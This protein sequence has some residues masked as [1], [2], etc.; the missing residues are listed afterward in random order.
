MGCRCCR[1]DGRSDR[2]SHSR[3]IGTQ[4]RAVTKITDNRTALIVRQVDELWT[5]VE[6]I[7]A[8][9]RCSWFG[10][11]PELDVDRKVHKHFPLSLFKRRDFKVELM[12]DGKQADIYVYCRGEEYDKEYLEKLGALLEQNNFEVTAYLVE[13]C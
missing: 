3:R 12:K 6:G 13:D 7:D 4:E 5:K 10:G 1:S 9:Y 8:N 2:V 11:Q